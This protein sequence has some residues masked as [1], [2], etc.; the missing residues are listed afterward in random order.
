[1]MI[2]CLTSQIMENNSAHS[3]TSVKGK[4]RFK[5][6]GKISELEEF[7][8]HDTVEVIS[9]DARGCE[10]SF[11]FQECFI[12]VVQYYEVKHTKDGK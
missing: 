3:F 11:M 1:M 10:Q 6:I 4:K 2:N 9:V 7:V 5:I 12:A 8:N